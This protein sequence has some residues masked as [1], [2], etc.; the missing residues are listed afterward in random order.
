MAIYYKYF[1]YESY[2][3]QLR[4]CCQIDLFKDYKKTRGKELRNPNIQIF[5][6]NMVH[7][8]LHNNWGIDVTVN[9]KINIKTHRINGILV[10]VNFSLPHKFM[11]KTWVWQ[12]CCVW[13]SCVFFVCEHWM[14]CIHVHVVDC[15]LL[16][17][18]KHNFCDFMLRFLHTKALLK[19]G[20][21]SKEKNPRVANS[22]PLEST[23]FQLGGKKYRNNP[24]YWD[25]NAWANSE[26]PDQTP[27][28]AA[29]DQGL[30]CL[31][32][33]KQYFKRLNRW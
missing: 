14:A 3:Y 23:I 30:H 32:L 1:S 15:S 25:R 13:F 19:R 20:L 26:D 17:Q 8:N 27:Q 16:L 6:L 18:G 12:S 31:P 24:K 33:I 29:S 4:L 21:H 5:R 11:C 9:L 22:F 7:W 2:A 28:S 10:F